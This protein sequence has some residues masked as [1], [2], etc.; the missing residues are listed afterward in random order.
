MKNWRTDR[1]SMREAHVYRL[2]SQ[3]SSSFGRQA[4]T[5]GSVFIPP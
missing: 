1:I 2:D 3:R 4:I 5:S